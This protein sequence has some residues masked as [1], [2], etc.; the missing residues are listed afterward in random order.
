MPKTR[1]R[2][3]PSP[4]EVFSRLLDPAHRADP[5]PIHEQLRRTAVADIG[6]GFWAVSGHEEIAYL[7]RHPGVSK[8]ERKSRVAAG[9]IRELASRFFLFLDP[10]E[11][12]RLRRLTM[13]Q[14]TPARVTRM[15]GRVVTLVE[16]VLDAQR[17]RDDLDV[18]ADF[19]YPLP[20]T[21]ICELLGIPRADERR[22]HVWADVVAHGLD[23][24]SD[25]E[26]QDRL[27][28]AARELRDYVSALVD[29]R[30]ARP[31]DD[32]I[33]GLAAGTGPADTMADVDLVSTMVLML[34]AG[35]ETTVNLITN[36]VLTLLRHPDELDLLR[37]DPGRSVPVVEELL[38][39]EPPVQF[40]TR[41][42]LTD[43]EVG[44][45]TIPA[46]AG[47]RLVFA[48]GNRDPRHVVEPDR[49]DPDRGGIEHLGFGGGI[50][51]CVGAPLARLEA[52]IA[53]AA[54]ARKVR[55][56]RLL[57][58]PPPYRSNAVLRGP[59]HLLVGF[60]DIVP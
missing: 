7:L 54:F 36:G 50:H 4:G 40:G 16:E 19:A 41:F 13:D 59:E 1:T 5:Y 25:P 42:A 48:A 26:L 33:S 46:G 12:D 3:S 31:E 28:G 20:V 60:D 2:T 49:F 57:A 29:E 6:D 38:R 39:F 34:I 22:F 9:G 18:V 52:Q 35:H 15:R 10:P 8:E 45:A 58:D 47:I 51:Y 11:H 30:R 56:P 14:F 37:A 44:G 32:L 53:L 21:V 23:P 43:L 17:G 55:S 24:D 27:R